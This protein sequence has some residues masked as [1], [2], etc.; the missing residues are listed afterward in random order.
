MDGITS[1][2]GSARLDDLRTN[3]SP[4]PENGTR[5]KLKFSELIGSLYDFHAHLAKLSL[6]NELNSDQLPCM[7]L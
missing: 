6:G 2:A 3:I 5:F 7:V 1:I 4:Y